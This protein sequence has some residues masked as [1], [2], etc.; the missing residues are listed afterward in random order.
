MKRL[1]FLVSLCLLMLALGHGYYALTGDFQ[2]S[3]LLQAEANGI[4]AGV[5]PSVVP[6]REFTYLGHGHQSFAFLS[7]DGTVVL[8][9]FKNDYLNRSAWKNVI[10]PIF[11][12]RPL[13][14]YTGEGKASRMRRLLNGYEAAFAYDRENA[15]LLAFHQYKTGCPL[16]CTLVDA[17]GAKQTLNLDDY[18]FALQVKA[19]PFRKEMSSLDQE[20][21]DRRLQQLET[22]YLAEA[23]RKI[24]D[25]DHN[26][27][28]NIG[29][30]DDRAIR[31]DSGKIE[32]RPDLDAEAFH[33]NYRK[34]VENRLRPK[35]PG[36]L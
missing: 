27:F 3:Q 9:L 33:R 8:K 23:E 2:I 7:R 32:Y 13:F 29:F 36:T 28:D 31:I 1:I 11:F 4:G 16:P 24:L 14:L 19:V 26:V 17:L 30:L 21:R 18:V 12:L 25:H 22:L 34:I 35:Y 15:G 5:A 6:S 20:G 10:P